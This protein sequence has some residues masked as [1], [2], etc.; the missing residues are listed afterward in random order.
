MDIKSELDLS[1]KLIIKVQLGDDI[2]RIPI[3][4]E[5]LTYDELVLMMQR[6]FRGKLS[7]NDDITIKYKDEDG[8]LITIFESN[9]LSFAIQSSRILKLQILLNSEL[10]TDATSALSSTEV[11]NLKKQLRNIRDQVND[12]LDSIDV[13]ENKVA[14]GAHQESGETSNIDS[15]QSASSLNKVNSGEFDPLQDKNQKNGTEDHKESSKPSTPQINNEGASSRPQSVS[16]ATTPGQQSVVTSAAANPHMTDYFGRSSNAAN[17]PGMQYGSLPYPQQY[18]FQTTGR[19]VPQVMDSSQVPSSNAYSNPS[20][21][22]LAYPQQQQY[23]HP[24]GSV[25][26]PTSAQGNPYS[27]GFTQPSPQHGFMPPRQ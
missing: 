13:N 27:K 4:N 11:I 6:V 2:R 22:S 1:G 3:H 24:P 18:T 8:D 9:D 26:Y 14:S 12:I 20:Q 15:N 25:V 10:K 17:F 7:A 5:S 16:M 19:Y 23:G 21:A